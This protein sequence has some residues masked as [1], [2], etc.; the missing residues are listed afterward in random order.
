MQDTKGKLIFLNNLSN[1]LVA[2]LGFLMPVFFLATTTE[3]FEF[4]KLALLTVGTLVTILVWAIKVGSGSEIKLVRSKMDLPLFAMLAVFLIATVFSV[5]K[6]SSIWGSQGRWFPSLFG[7]LVMLIFYYVSSSSF[8]SVKMIRLALRSFIA[9][10]TVSSVVATLSYFNIFIGTE[11]YMKSQAFNLAGSVTT[12]IFIAAV[13]GIIAIKE[14]YHARFLPAKVALGLAALLNLLF[15][16]L[17]GTIMGWVLLVLGVAGLA[18]TLKTEELLDQRVLTM[19]ASSVFVVM[20]LL[21]LLPATRNLIRS[22]SYPYEIGLPL[23][24]SWMVASATIQEY[25]FV[26][27]GPSTFYLNFTRFRPL[28]LNSTNLWNLRFDKPYNEFFNTL[29]TTGIVGLLVLVF[30]LTRAVRGGLNAIR[31]NDEEGTFSTIGIAVLLS[32]AALFFTYS[33]VLNT[34][35]LFFML[36]LMTAAN[37]LKDQHVKWGEVISFSVASISSVTTTIGDASVIKKE[38]ANIVAAAPIALLAI[39]GTYL[40]GKT[41]VAEYYM[42]ESIVA[43]LDGQATSTYNLQAKAI[44]MN[45]NRDSYHTA[46]AQTN[47]LLAN[48]LAAN[49]NLTEQDKTTIQTL[50]S[51]SIRSAR[52]ATEVVNPLN[53]VNW[54]TRALVYRSLISVADNASEWAINSYNTAI[55]LDPTNPS[56]RLDLGG[57]Y[58]TQKDFLSAANMFRQATALKNDYANAHYNF[59]QALVNLNDFNGAKRELEVTRGLV[60]PDSEDY[61]RVQEEIAGLTVPAA[62]QVA[63]AATEAPKPTVEQIT[64]AQAPATPQENLATPTEQQEAVQNPNI[65]P[66][67]LPNQEGQPQP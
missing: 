12:A 58:F 60:A 6:T 46:Y 59:A 65:K 10:A 26:A 28:R 9:G 38:Y 42:R 23:R 43:A 39:A 66:E 27:T 52:Q 51:Q 21:S 36:S 41:Y 16:T 56:I 37:A 49:Q 25:P 3:F 40:F 5:N 19:A 55:Q 61:K 48:A 29:G 11:A 57:V 45:P 2:A 8:N 17:T 44:N 34:F 14:T 15:V 24:E 50:V 33:T 18:L 54:Q 63:G 22:E 47:L 31:S 62:P 4:N 32:T 7:M 30:F 67:T 35:V 1:F 13:A 64:G 20:A 53:V